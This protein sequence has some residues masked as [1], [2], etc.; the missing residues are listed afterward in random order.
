MSR[1]KPRDPNS[2]SYLPLPAP[3]QFSLSTLD[4]ALFIA[5]ALGF[6]SGFKHAFE[7]DHLVA[8]S[9]LLHEKPQL[10]NALR[11][12]LA[13]GAGHTTT[14]VLAVLLVGA[15]RIQINETHLAYFELPVAAM[16][17]GLG[18]WTVFVALRRALSLR[19]HQHSAGDAASIPHY[20]LGPDDHPHG[21]STRR[22][23]WGGYVV[24]LIHGLA[25]SG[26][27][28]LLVAATLPTLRASF[29]YALMF[30]AGSII[31]MGAVT[32][33]LALPLIA[34][35]SRPVFYNALTAFA[36]IM[37]VALGVSILVAVLG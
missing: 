8:V 4:L 9:A 32:T 22:A 31:G 2:S 29:V 20:H 34:S 19:K 5:F 21:F 25:G 18:G 23:G 24:G 27:L 35:Q 7:P 12:G 14:L 11:T 28:L 17:L 13:W 10:R 30:G 1:A 33:A 37:S 6:L 15:L 36:G 16:L 3:P 26:A